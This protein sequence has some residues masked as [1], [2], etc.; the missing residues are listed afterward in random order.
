MASLPTHPLG[1]HFLQ[2]EER[3]RRDPGSS[4]CDP[5]PH[6]LLLLRPLSRTSHRA[7]RS[8][9][10]S[11]GMPS[12]QGDTCLTKTQ[13]VS[14]EK[15]KREN[16]CGEAASSLWHRKSQVLEQEKKCTEREGLDYTQAMLGRAVKAWRA[17]WAR[18]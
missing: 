16:G 17:V 18:A 2:E 13:R 10:G 5:S 12:S 7:T 15:K 8:H 4:R 11:W 3:E 6:T 14:F 9:E 1:L